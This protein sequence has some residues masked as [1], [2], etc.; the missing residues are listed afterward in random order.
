M[1]DYSFEGN[2][3]RARSLGQSLKSFT[4]YG[5]SGDY[6]FCAIWHEDSSSDS[7]FNNI[8]TYRSPA[9]ADQ[10]QAVVDTETSKPYWRP[11]SISISEDGGYT[12][13]WTDTDIGSWDL[14]YD[15]SAAELDSEIKKQNS[16]GKYPVRL[17]GGGS[18]ETAKYAAIFAPQDL[19]S[20]RNWRV[21][22]P[23]TTGLTDNGA[24]AESIIQGFMQKSGVRQVQLSIARN[25]ESLLDKAYTWSE[26][27]R[28][29]TQ[30]NDTFLLASVSKAFCAAAIQSLYDAN[31]LTPD[32]KVYPLL[33]Y[34]NPADARQQDITVQQ[35]VEHTAGFKRSV[36]GDPAY[37]MRE[38]ALAQSAGERP[39]SLK[40]TVDYMYKQQLDYTP[41][42]DYEY[43]NYNYMLL[44]Y[45]VEH[46]TNQPYF[47]Y[48]SSAILSPEALNVKRWLTDPATHAADNVIQESAST[49]PS[50]RQPLAAN[51]V[52][53]VYGGD[54]QFKDAT[55]GT[56]GLAASAQSLVA[57]ARTHAAYGIGGRGAGYRDGTTSGARTYVESRWDGVDWAL[58]INTRDFPNGDGDFN[59]VTGAVNAWLDGLGN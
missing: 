40:D 14:R 57:F 42:T 35:L 45:V 43:G 41:G 18:G 56:T 47:T 12:S 4:Q 36:S 39:A 31:K 1:T 48:L 16:E 22:G 23:S 49:G 37:E 44:S 53:H 10:F 34:S 54:G 55:L 15:L 2:N 30:V 6:R 20:K 9:L 51:A 46:V 8:Q 58:T 19:P 27:E 26:P 28:V 13:M 59:D 24:K 25:G 17:S 21:T 52:A 11:E 32:T 33:G 38:I 5:S 29:T 3:Q 50:A 7:S